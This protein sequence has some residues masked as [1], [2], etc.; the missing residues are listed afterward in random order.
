MV[1]FGADWRY[2]GAGERMAWYGSVTLL[3]QGR[4]GEWSDVLAEVARRLQ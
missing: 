2:G 4:V 1:P 3:R